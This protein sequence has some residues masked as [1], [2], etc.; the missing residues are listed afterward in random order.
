[1][2]L[3]NGCWPC[4]ARPAALYPLLQAYYHGHSFPTTDSACHPYLLLHPLQLNEQAL[5]IC[6]NALESTHAAVSTHLVIHA[7]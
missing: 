5:P 3:L 4:C 7:T 2:F 1:M 6:L